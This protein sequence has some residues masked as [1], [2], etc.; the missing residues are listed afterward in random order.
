MGRTI[1]VWS[2]EHIAVGLIE[3][4]RL[5]G[6]LRIYPEDPDDSGVLQG[7]PSETIAHRICHEVNEAR[8]GASIEAVGVGFP[9]I[10]LAGTVEE[11]PNLQQVKGFNLQQA[12]SA[13][14]LEVSV[15]APVLVLNDADAMA[16]GI[17]ATS[18]Q[19]DKHVR[20]WT[21]GEGIGFGR[22]PRTDGI[23]EGGHSVVSLDPKEHYCGCGGQG[24]LE[25]IMGIR[26]MRL[27]FLDME[28]EEVFEEAKS[29]DA[30]C[31]EFVRM[32]HRALAAA[33]A[34]SI[35]MEGGGKF[36]IGGP[37]AKF[38]DI[39]LLTEYVNEMVKMSPLQGYSFEVFPSS[40]EIGVIG[41][42]LNAQRAAAAA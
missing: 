27:R 28:P 14:L 4:G 25:G 32:W 2:A 38:L 21:L 20:V 23:W 5:A 31:L 33:S 10:I 26:S 22:Y 39:R 35:H 9:G 37:N 30:R 17:A 11:S 1:G 24:H 6:S 16:A 42:A 13:A 18:G 36:F 3:N 12:L 34:T 29:G 7:M 40:D 41:A 8:Q 15:S 19:L